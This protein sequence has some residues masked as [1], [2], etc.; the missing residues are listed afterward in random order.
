MDLDFGYPD[1]FMNEVRQMEEDLAD[2]HIGH[3]EFNRCMAELEDQL[4]QEEYDR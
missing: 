3:S 2:G 4:D 1:W